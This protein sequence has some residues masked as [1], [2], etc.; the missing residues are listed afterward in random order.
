MPSPVEGKPASYP[1]V[2]SHRWIPVGNPLAK[3]GPYAGL[4]RHFVEKD[5]CSQSELVGEVVYSVGAAGERTSFARMDWFPFAEPEEA[6]AGVGT[7]RF[8]DTPR[9]RLQCQM[10]TRR[11]AFGVR[12]DSCSGGVF[13]QPVW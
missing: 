3:V 6:V 9:E 12:K 4:R 11:K 8:A 13:H 7:S 2:L 10:R 5:S 1:D